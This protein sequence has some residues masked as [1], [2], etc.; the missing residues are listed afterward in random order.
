MGFAARAVNFIKA[1]R[2]GA[3]RSALQKGKRGG[4]FYTSATGRKVYADKLP[5]A[6]NQMPV[7]VKHQPGHD[8][9]K[10]LA[11]GGDRMRAM[12]RTDAMKKIGGAAKARL[13]HAG[14]AIREA[15]HGGAEHAKQLHLGGKMLAQQAGAAAKGAAGAIHGAAQAAGSKLKKLRE[16]GQRVKTGVKNNETLGYAGGVA[17]LTMQQARGKLA[18]GAK[19]GGGLLKRG[20]HKIVDAIKN[21]AAKR[22]E[23]RVERKADP[24]GVQARKH[25]EAAGKALARGDTNRAMASLLE[26]HRSQQLQHV[27]RLVKGGDTEGAIRALMRAQQKGVLYQQQ[28]TTVE[29]AAQEATAAAKDGRSRHPH[30]GRFLP[31]S[32]PN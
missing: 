10:A 29:T 26:A 18:K 31:K 15:M 14:T 9:G 22:R 11:R 21:F 27:E 5:D 28:H 20:F 4:Q 30:T 23:E 16:L 32:A 1:Q 7:A 24:H 8:L 13:G 3:I 19:A 6:H 2:H 12:R 25:T 17:K